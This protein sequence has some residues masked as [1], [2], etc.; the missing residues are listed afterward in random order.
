MAAQIAVNELLFLMD[1]AF[2]RSR[3]HSLLNNLSA[4]TEDDYAREH[5]GRSIREMVRH[6]TAAKHV[7]DNQAFGDGSLFMPSFQDRIYGSSA[8]MAEDLD[9]LHHGYETLRASVAALDDAD[10]AQPRPVH[11]GGTL[12]TRAIIS[13]MIEHD[14]YHAGEINHLR[15]LMQ[16]TDYW[17]GREP[18]K[19]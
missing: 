14:V 16:G 8:G 17:R 18:S 1:N 2:E 6:L 19:A 15:A 4:V 11:M 10:L 5:A 9:W 3:A 13:I 7:Y 12:E